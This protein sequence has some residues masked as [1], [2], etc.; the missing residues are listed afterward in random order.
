MSEESPQRRNPWHDRIKGAEITDP[1][2]LAKYQ[3]DDGT[4]MIAQNVL[5]AIEDA[6]DL[7]RD[8]LNVVVRLI[9][10]LTLEQKHSL[11]ER[12]PDLVVGTPPNGVPHSEAG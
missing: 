6:P 7:K 4:T 12:F 11:T 2:E 3:A 1:E 10:H 8:L 9:G 5:C